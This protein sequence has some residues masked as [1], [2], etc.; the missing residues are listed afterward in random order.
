MSKEQSRIILPNS[1]LAR[2]EGLIDVGEHLAKLEQDKLDEA[3][4][5]K[6]GVISQR[7]VIPLAKIEQ[8]LLF[9]KP[10][11][12]SVTIDGR[13]LNGI[14]AYNLGD[15]TKTDQPNQGP[16]IALC[17]LMALEAIRMMGDTMPTV[18][19]PQSMVFGTE[20][21]QQIADF[22]KGTFAPT[23]FQ[24]QWAW[25]AALAVMAG[26]PAATAELLETYTEQLP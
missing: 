15:P 21:E 10:I 2:R 18:E 23:L 7:V 24:A 16:C 11:Y 19:D 17:N 9:W 4:D 26:E 13:H 22:W 25:A 20:R 5:S 6:E 8:A 14:E 3:L 1:P 12:L